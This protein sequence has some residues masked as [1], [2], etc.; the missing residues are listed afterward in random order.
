M[1]T[2]K[3]ML[4]AIEAHK[5]LSSKQKLAFDDC[6]NAVVDRGLSYEQAKRV[7]RVL[8][9]I[10]HGEMLNRKIKS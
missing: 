4:T 8:D 5:N 3:R 6:K 1:I 2:D 10:L 9:E 7:L